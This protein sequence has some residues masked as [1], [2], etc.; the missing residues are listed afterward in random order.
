LAGA[1]LPA[2]PQ[3]AHLERPARVL[4]GWLTPDEA[5][6]HATGFG[7]R[8]LAP[9]AED[10]TNRSIAAVDA[11][12]VGIDQNGL[13][14]DTPVELNEHVER[15]R[16]TAPAYFN[17]GW[18]VAIVDLSRVCAI[19]P[20][21]YSDQAQQRVQQVNAEEIVSIASVTLPLPTPA[22][23]PILYDD[24]QKSWIITS[25]NPNLRIMTNV[26]SQAQE[27]VSAVGFAVTIMPSYL[28]VACVQG[29]YILRDGYHR[30]FG[31]LRRGIRLAPAFVRDAASVEE[32]RLPAGLLRQISFL[33]DRPPTLTDYFDDQVS[34]E[35]PLPAIQK[36]IVIHGIELSLLA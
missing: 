28:Q 3:A 9:E 32:L 30:A 19:Q 13:I 5:R 31:L 34:K 18:R 7:T 15:L 8:P 1:N 12:A 25:P 29:R 26:S 20:F 10:A 27:G 33:G 11:R 6:R 35:M 16:Q 2:L 14:S 4:L 23:L 24:A 17:E 21:V 36:M 22:S